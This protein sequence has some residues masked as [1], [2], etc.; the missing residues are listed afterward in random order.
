MALC[1][2][3][4]IAQDGNKLTYNASLC[5]GCCGC[6]NVCP[7]NAWQTKWFSAQYYNKG[8]NVPRMVKAMK[9]D[10]GPAKTGPHSQARK[11]NTSPA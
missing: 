6:I 11:T 4:A 5:L 3:G 9:K 8:M 2:S 1:P 10:P 7:Q